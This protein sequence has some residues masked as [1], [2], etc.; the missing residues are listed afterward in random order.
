MN[1]LKPES[2]HKREPAQNYN[3]YLE[4][5]FAR[6]QISSTTFDNFYNSTK[7]LS[8][9]PNPI[10]PTHQGSALIELKGWKNRF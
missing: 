4:S 5:A 6:G 1:N 7:K 8:G 2:S 10:E 3:S 9:K